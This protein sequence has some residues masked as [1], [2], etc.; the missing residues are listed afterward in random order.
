MNYIYIDL[1]A[2]D[3]DSIH[4]FMKM[5]KLPVPAGQFKIYAFEPNPNL[6]T[7]LY[8]LI[9]QYENIME[10]DTGAA[11]VKDEIREFAVDTTATPMGSTLMPGKVA[12][13]DNFDKYEVHCFNFSSWLK[14]FQND[15]VIVKC[16]I[17]GAEFPLLEKLIRDGTDKIINQLW[18]ET[19]PNKVKEYTSKYS[20]NLIKRLSCDLVKEWH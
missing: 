9:E 1:G 13:W 7:K 6:F 17:E 19:H 11:W 8:P 4:E 12:I 2:Y 10:I 3:G 15:Y 18:L 16:D 14:Q 20:E 5:S